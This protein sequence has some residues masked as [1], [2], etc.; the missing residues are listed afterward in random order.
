MLIFNMLENVPGFTELGNVTLK[1]VE[2][3]RSYPYAKIFLLLR[4]L[5]LLLFS[6]LTGCIYL[7]LSS[8]LHPHMRCGVDQSY[9]RGDSS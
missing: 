4:G 8:F 3:P 2:P 6:S 7:L 9:P 5:L 1:I